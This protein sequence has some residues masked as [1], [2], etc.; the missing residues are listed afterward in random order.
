MATPIQKLSA[1]SR[2]SRSLARWNSPSADPAI[3]PVI[4]RVQPSDWSVGRSVDLSVGLLEM[5]QTS[6]TVYIHRTPETTPMLA[7]MAVPWSVCA[8]SKPF[9]PRFRCRDQGSNLESTRF[10]FLGTCRKGR[11]CVLEVEFNRSKIVAYSWPGWGRSKVSSGSIQACDWG[12]SCGCPRRRSTW[13]LSRRSR[14]FRFWGKRSL[15]V[16]PSHRFQEA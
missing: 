3:P 16:W 4:Q 13:M 1:F 12:R 10:S 2:A 6:Q 11:T 5:P 8:C 15:R 9:K 7:Y 14:R